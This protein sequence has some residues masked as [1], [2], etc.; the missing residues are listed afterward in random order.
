MNN[1]KIIKGFLPRQSNVIEA[2]FNE[3]YIALRLKEGRIYSD[4]ELGLLPKVPPFHRHFKEWN[5][6]RHSSDKLLQYIR[7]NSRTCNILEIGC[8]NGWLSAK[9]ATVAKGDVTGID[10][11]LVELGQ[12]RKVFRKVSNLQFMFGDIRSGILQDKRYD[13]IVFA[14]SIQYFP[15]LYDILKVALRHLTLQGE[16]HILD[17]HLYRFNEIEEARQRSKKYYTQSGFFEMSKY[18]FH[19]SIEDLRP[20]CFSMVHNP[21]TLKNKLM[22]RKNP[23]HWIIIKNS[24]C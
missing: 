4:M 19:H 17:S 2:R 3:L 23:F 22:F 5:I 7:R 9:L 18:Y 13:L 21:H 8:G 14:A 16:I 20:F 10:I 12:A 6:R 15:S 11:N 24:Y 1:L